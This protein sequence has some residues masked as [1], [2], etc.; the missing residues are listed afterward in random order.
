VRGN[1][2]GN[3][4]L[5]LTEET[6]TE[7]L[8]G[9]MD[10]PIKTAS[11][12]HLI[13]CDECRGRLAF[14]MRVLEG[15]VLADENLALKAI[16]TEWDKKKLQH[17]LPPRSGTHSVWL[18]SLIAVAAAMIL[19]VV[20]LHYVEDRRAEPKSASEIVQLLLAQN[21][22][23]EARLAGEPHIT[24]Q[25]TRGLEDP[26]IA[27]EVLAGEMTRHSADSHEMGRFYLLQKDFA[28]A[29][30]YLDI[31][32][33]EVGAGA[34]VHNDLGVAFLE[35]GEAG[36]VAKAGQEFRHALELDPGFAPAVFNLALFYE[37]IN[38]PAQA[39]A[40]WKQYLQVDATSDWAGEA[41]TRL[42]GLSR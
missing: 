34:A 20:S 37:R 2:Q 41:R 22:P 19:A 7:Y 36:R 35:S 21:R 18:W 38:D 11:E 28:R 9:G 26:G 30:P 31:A 16:N 12:A 29:L 10:P 14:F 23:F 15:G 1:D 32:E 8:E 42:Q 40:Q 5:C 39:A 27:Y 25:R 33:R 13:A 4:G 24:I 17:G 3:H 6:L